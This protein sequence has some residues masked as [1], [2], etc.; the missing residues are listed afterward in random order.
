MK[1]PFQ[2]FLIVM[3]AAL[4]LAVTVL[5]AVAVPLMLAT[6]NRPAWLWRPWFNPEEG[7]GLPAWYP[8]YISRYGNWLSRRFPRW[9]WNAIRNPANGLRTYSVLS[10]EIEPSRVRTIG[11]GLPSNPAPL[12]KAGGRFSWFYAW[13]DNYAGFWICAIWSATKHMKLRIG[14]KILPDD[15][16]EV[17]EE[18]RADKAGFA[19]SVLPWRRG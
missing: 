1:V 8:R 3:M 10:V 11:N 17:S 18:W 16:D 12:R 6:S 4:K 7:L 15:V 14:W 5:G 19:F 13:Q 2:L 9:W